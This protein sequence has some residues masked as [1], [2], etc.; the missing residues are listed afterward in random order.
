M[1]A[2]T[3][4]RVS[5]VTFPNVILAAVFLVKAKISAKG[6]PYPKPGRGYVRRSW[7]IRELRLYDALAGA[8]LL[9]EA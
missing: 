7:T 1:K 3:I 2:E 5:D 6:N 8:G 9:E 4:A